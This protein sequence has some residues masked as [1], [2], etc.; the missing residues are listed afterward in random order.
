MPRGIQKKGI[1]REKKMLYAAI[2]QFLENGYERTTTAAIAK[3]AGMAPSSFCAAFENKEALLLRLVQEMFH[4]QFFQSE[5]LLPCNGDPVFLYSIET[6]LQ[7]HITE[8][9]EALRELYVAAYTLP[10]T[11]EYINVNTAKKLQQL[12]AE[13]LPDATEKDFYEMD[14]ASCGITRNFMARPCSMY[15]TIEDKI[16]RYLS[17]C[18][19]LYHVPEKKQLDTIDS[20][21]SMDLR[22]IAE[23]LI[24]DTIDRAEKGFE[25]AGITKR[26]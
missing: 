12:F 15:F 6:S 25:S 2:Q 24:K 21:L 19:T 18:L 14:L 17:C 26:D 5:A 9:S 1:V 11:A 10:T 23:K 20:I 22:T 7:L 8:I 4:S 16:S 3:A 13:Y